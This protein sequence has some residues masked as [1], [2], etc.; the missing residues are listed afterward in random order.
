MV[1]AHEYLT[2]HRR[3]DS[4]DRRI[5]ASEIIGVHYHSPQFHTDICCDWRV[6]AGR[7]ARDAR[8]LVA[9]PFITLLPLPNQIG[10]GTSV[11][12]SVTVICVPTT[13]VVSSSVTVPGALLIINV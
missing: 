7:S 13:G 4:T 12:A 6:S 2:R 3:R 8:P 10:S 1:Q 11:S 9:R 5:P